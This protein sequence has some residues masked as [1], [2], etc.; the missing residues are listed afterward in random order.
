[1][2]PR[3][4]QQLLTAAIE[5]EGEG[6]REL[7]ADHPDE[8]RV[9][10]REAADMYRQSW[11]AAPPGSFGRLVGMLKCAVLAGGG[12]REAR[13][14]RR[15]LGD[16][17]RAGAESPTASYAQALA[18]LILDLDVEAQ[19]W[20]LAM[21]AGS[22]AF[23]RTAEAVAALAAWDGGRYAVALAE[24]VHDFEAR[25]EHLTGVAIADTAVVLDVLAAR[26]GF[27]VTMASPVLPAPS[28]LDFGREEL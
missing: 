17:A 19:V 5:R 25:T 24:I 18:A 15:A 20:A 10:F 4:H 1:M 8:A 2:A 12:A 23:K 9:A 3:K 26:R 28:A 27:A 14:A 21:S 11:E 7:M 16:A 13:Y 6:Q 22:D